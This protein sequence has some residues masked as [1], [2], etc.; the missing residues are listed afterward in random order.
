MLWGETNK[1]KKE[2]INQTNKQT[3]VFVLMRLYYWF[4]KMIAMNDANIANLD[5][6]PPKKEKL[7]LV[8]LIL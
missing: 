2:R 8:L 7:K 5:V 3:N 4:H 6:A 1:P